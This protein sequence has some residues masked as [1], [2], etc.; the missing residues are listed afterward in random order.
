MK[1]LRLLPFLSLLSFSNLGFGQ[2]PS[3][4]TFVTIDVTT[5][6]WGYECFWDLTPMGAGC[7][8]SEIYAYGNT[9]QVGCGGAG[10]QD[11]NG[12]GYPNNTMTTESL[13]CVDFGNCFDINYVDDWGDGGATFSVNFD[14]LQAY[15]FGGTGTGNVFSF[16]VT[17]NV[18]F[19]ASIAANHF[20][21]TKIPLSQAQ[22]ILQSG[23]VSSDG[24]G[25]ITNAFMNVSV[26][27]NGTQ[28]F[29]TNSSTQNIASGGNAAFSTTGYTPT[30]TGLYTVT[31]FADMTENDGNL[32][33]NYYSYTVDITDSIYARDNGA[34]YGIIGIGT[35]EPGYLANRFTILNPIQLSSISVFLGNTTGAI[36]NNPFDVEVFIV[37]AGTATSIATAS[38]I[39]S[40]SAYQW[41]TVDLSPYPILIPGEY[42]VAL[43]ETN[44]EQEVGLNEAVFTPN[45]SF[46]T[47]TSQPWASTESLELDVNFMIRLNVNQNAQLSENTLTELSIFPNP[48]KNT[49][50]INGLL[51]NEEIQFVDNLGKVVYSTT[52][53]SAMQTID[54]SEFD[55]GIYL[56]K[57]EHHL[58]TKI[59]KQ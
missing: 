53:N 43:K 21:Y 23:V 33:N 2:C 3:G 20:Q 30:E 6:A 51:P 26:S 9:A 24:Y 11:A 27:K 13:G 7:G 49:L 8:N 48:A 50:T 46:V 45:T 31:Y 47:W 17:T 37:N 4:Q 22:N 14:G 15:Y 29:T 54:L 44:Y 1:S 39:V 58:I 36:S 10:Q 38:G 59:I 41:H 16:C 18:E 19:D 35:G 52:S 34:S 55:S 42:L 12:G 25:N 5:D 40:S 28:V 32:S 57:T 56:L